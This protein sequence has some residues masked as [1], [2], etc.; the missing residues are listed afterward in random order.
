MSDYTPVMLPGM[1]WTSQAATAVTGG[2]PLEVTGPGVVARCA[3]AASPAYVGIAAGDA[4]AGHTVTVI[5][6]RPVHE[7]AADGPVTA[8]DQLVASAVAGRQVAALDPAAVTLAGT[9]SA[10]EVMAA[11]D[12]AINAAR[13]VIGVALTTATD[14][15]TVRWQQRH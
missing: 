4:P 5:S 10:A 14:G 13:A 1:T 3:A 9:Y 2:D 8:G 15:N 6:V 7:G 11:V 12:A